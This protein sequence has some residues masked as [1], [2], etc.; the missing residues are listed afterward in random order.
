MLPADQSTHTS[1]D[2]MNSFE[3]SS[4]SLA[5]DEPLGERWDELSMVV[6][7]LAFLG[8]CKQR[9]VERSVSRPGVDSFVRADDYGNSL[10]SGGPL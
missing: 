2:S 4:V 6:Y 3:T 8:D 1:S 7:E 9:V 10:I 5:P